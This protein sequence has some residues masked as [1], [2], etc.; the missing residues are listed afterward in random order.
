MIVCPAD[1]LITREDKFTASVL[2][3]FAFVEANEAL[4]TLGITPTRPETGYGYI[5][6]GEPVCGDISKVKTF[7]EKFFW[8][9]GIF[10]WSCKA[11]RKALR[12]C[13][14]DISRV[15][16]STDDDTYLTIDRE[17][18]FIESAFPSC[19]SISIDYAVRA[20]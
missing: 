2:N 14:P 19:V 18:M 7:T 8:N 5:Q 3:G 4:L 9:S 12:K 6:V 10:M 20:T 16:D 1:H 11:I 15:F 17:R 13:I